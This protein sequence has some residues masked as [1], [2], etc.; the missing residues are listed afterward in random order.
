MLETITPAKALQIILGRRCPRAARVC[1]IDGYEWFHNH[2]PENNTISQ[3]K[4]V[5]KELYYQA[6]EASKLLTDAVKSLAIRL[7]GYLYKGGMLDESER[8]MI[9]PEDKRT[10]DLDIFERELDCGKRK[11]GKVDC[12]KQDVLKVAG[13]QREKSMCTLADYTGHWNNV[14]AETGWPPSVGEDRQW[15]RDECL[16]VVSVRVCRK[17]FVAQL[18][19]KERRAFSKGGRRPRSR[20]AQ[21]GAAGAAVA[22]TVPT[23]QQ[24]LGD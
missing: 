2:D 6:R 11:F 24:Q 1:V 19:E 3:S 18:P 14:K 22:V 21:A 4:K 9:N 23:Q 7:R 15:A 5:E 12:I 8:I 13:R 17:K 16:S 20:S 10:G